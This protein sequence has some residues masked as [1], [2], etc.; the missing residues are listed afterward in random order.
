M[1]PMSANV[2]EMQKRRTLG[3]ICL[4]LRVF[5]P[6]IRRVNVIKRMIWSKINET[7]VAI[8]ARAGEERV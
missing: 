5:M 3:L 1:R 2:V 4:E 7:R 8:K 6:L